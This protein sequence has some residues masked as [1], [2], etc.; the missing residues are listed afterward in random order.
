M[1]EDQQNNQSTNSQVNPVEYLRQVQKSKELEM[2][3]S[4]LEKS[5]NE[6]KQM[7]QSKPSS[8]SDNLIASI[9]LEIIKGQNQTNQLFMQ[10]ML[11][12]MTNQN[13]NKSSGND[14]SNKLMEKLIEKTMNQLDT[15]KE[16]SEAQEFKEGLNMLADKIEEI[17]KQISEKGVTV[18]EEQKPKLKLL[19]SI[20]E[21]VNEYK[22]REELFNE[23][24]KVLNVKREDNM[25]FKD[26]IELIQNAITPVIE[27]VQTVLNVS[28]AQSVPVRQKE[29]KKAEVPNPPNPA[30]NPQNNVN[31]PSLPQPPKKEQIEIP[32]EKFTKKEKEELSKFLKFVDIDTPEGKKTVAQSK[33]GEYVGLEDSGT[34]LT[35]GQLAYLYHK[36][37]NFK[38]FIKSLDGGK[39]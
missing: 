5:M 21:I 7:L 9:I 28:Q 17:E 37:E 26:Y 24:G 32:E 15:P 14:L 35:E 10:N 25:S 3:M 34:I 16:S 30:P 31:T 18:P 4:E 13:Q 12:M 39:K 11:A 22:E 36:D 29:V 6:I 23:L 2:K 20:K 27:G 19:E 1:S 38:K 33:S 8:N